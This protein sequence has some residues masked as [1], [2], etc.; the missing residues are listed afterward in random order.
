[1]PVANLRNKLHSEKFFL[2]VSVVA[3]VVIAVTEI[4][5]SILTRSKAVLMDSVFDTAD[6]I[7]SALF[8]LILPLLYRPTTEKMPYGYAQLESVFMLIKGSMLFAV[9]ASIV[10]ESARTLLHGGSE[11]DALF[12]GMFELGQ[13]VICLVMLLVLRHMNRRVSSPAIRLEMVGWRIDVYCCAGVGLAFLSQLLFKNT[14]LAWIA[15]YIDPAI[16]IVMALVMLPEPVHMVVEAIRSIVLI[17]PGKETDAWIRGVVTE[18]LQDS[19]YRAA[20]YD[21]VK[22]GRKYWIEVY[23]RSDDGVFRLRE[24]RALKQS[25]EKRLLEKADNIYVELTPDSD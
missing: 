23:I 6:S 17:A 24:M 19:P 20:T 22:T 5:F 18:E 8:L 12:V 16:A 11:V 14:R 1:M 10:V 13:G 21:I 4:I 25:I 3:G 7:V 9:S 15:R 2:N